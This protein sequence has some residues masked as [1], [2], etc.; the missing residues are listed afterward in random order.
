MQKINKKGYI[1]MFLKSVALA[2][3]ILTAACS[4]KQSDPFMQPM[5]GTIPAAYEA[6]PVGQATTKIAVLLPLS[7]KSATVGADMQKAAMMAEFDRRR[8]GAAVV[9]Y[10]TAGTPQG[11]VTALEAAEKIKPA[12]IIGPVFSASVDAVKDEGP[13][14]PVLSFTSDTEVVDDDIYTLALT[15]PTQVDR[16]VQFACGQ[17]Q[18]KLAVIGPENKVGEIVMNALDKAVKRCPMMEMVQVSL[19]NPKTVNFDPVIAKIAPQPIDSR[20]KDLTD[21]EKELL[22]KPITEKVDFDSLFVFED[23][24]KLQQVMSM[25]SYYDITPSDIPVYGLSSWGGLRMS[26]LIGG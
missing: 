25:L 8:V 17:G 20:R 26:E 11:A 19:Y 14:V 7:G 1:K 4:I 12:L 16:I 13:S 9:F 3:L 22:A 23:G 24:I 21:K 2:G 15:I 6:M 10:D 5:F 18:K